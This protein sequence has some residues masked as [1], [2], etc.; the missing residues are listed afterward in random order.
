VLCALLLVLEAL[1]DGNWKL[2]FLLISVKAMLLPLLML[3]TVLQPTR[4]A[5]RVL[6]S[7]AFR[8]VGRLSYS[9]YLWQQ[10]FLVWAEDRVPAMGLLQSFP[11][12]L[13]AAFACAMLSLWLVE[14]PLIALGHRLI[15]RLQRKQR[16][17]SVRPPIS[18]SHHSC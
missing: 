1:S 16:I 10:L 2:S 5:G 15:Q 11:L 18:H 8:W 3:G 4:L 12:N 7:A 6:E 9:L 17:Q 14:T 13:A